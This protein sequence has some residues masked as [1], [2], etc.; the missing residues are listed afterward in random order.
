MPLLYAATLF[1]SA[2]LLFLVQPMFAKMVLPLLGGTPAVWNTCMVFYQAALLVGYV[3]AHVSI[4]LLGPRRQA[5]VHMVLVLL[6][7]LVLPIGVAAGQTPPSEANPIAWLLG[8][9]TLSVGLPFLA[10]SATGPMLQAWFADTRHP[11]ARDPYF[12]Y[13]AS[14]A[15]SMLAL[16]GYPTLIEP[17]L[18]LAWQSQVWTA[19][20]GLLVV[21]L[22][23][24]AVTC[25]R[26]RNATNRPPPGRADCAGCSWPSC[27]RACCWA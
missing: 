23:F 17:T 24:S 10:V 4:R 21:L 16:L 20:Y 12:L 13:A 7:C 25:R 18:S 19:G 22:F 1:A 14:N 6:P 11:S 5:T 8:L 26:R 9:L 3:Y 15:G 27:L 2:T